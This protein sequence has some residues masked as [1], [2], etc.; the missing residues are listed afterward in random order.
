MEKREK[1]VPVK[2]G[3]VNSSFCVVAGG[4]RGALKNS[5]L[6]MKI[7][8]PFIRPH[9]FPNRHDFPHNIKEKDKV[10]IFKAFNS[11]Q[12]AKD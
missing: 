6:I 9:I 4:I 1:T 3:R 2:T 8:S 11:V 5:E 10:Y 12:R 7:L